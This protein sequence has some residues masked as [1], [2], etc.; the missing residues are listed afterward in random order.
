[1][2]EREASMIAGGLAEVAKAIA[3]GAGN[4]RCKHRWMEPKRHTQMGVFVQLCRDCQKVR[5]V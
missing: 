2:S 1:M 3:A 4:V 5:R